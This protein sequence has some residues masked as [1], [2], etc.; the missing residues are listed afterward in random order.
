VPRPGVHSAADAARLREL[1]ELNVAALPDP[2]R[3]RAVLLDVEG[4][5]TPIDFVYKV[6]FLFS[7]ARLEDYLAR[8]SQEPETAA[9]IEALR[10]QRE[11]EARQNSAVP[12]W[13]ESSPEA[14]VKSAAE[15]C[16]W[17][18]DHDRKVTALKSLQGKI[19]EA[20]YR[21]GELRGEVYPDVAPAFARWRKQ[22]RDIAI[23]SSGSVLAQKLIFGCSTAGDLTLHIRAYFDTTTGA[24]REDASYRRI[25]AALG[26]RPD[27]VVFLS[28]VIAELDAARAAGMAALLVVRP[29]ARAPASS[30]HAAIRSFDEVLT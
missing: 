14:R 28:D 18:I 21:S 8:H 7:R 1:N 22:G 5:T 17:L 11:I 23:F 12:E 25:A 13:S 30:T 27:E 26:R 3:I 2:A 15:F 19:W 29:G 20:G 6:L 24:K 16:R 10:Q 9:E 4:T